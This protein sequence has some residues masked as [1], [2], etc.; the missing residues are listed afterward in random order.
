MTTPVLAT[1]PQTLNSYG[2]VA[3]VQNQGEQAVVRCRH[4]GFRR[5]PG[6]CMNLRRAKREDF[7]IPAFAGMTVINW[8]P[9]KGE[10]WGRAAIRVAPTM[11]TGTGQEDSWVGRGGHKGRPYEVGL[12]YAAGGGPGMGA[13]PCFHSTAGYVPMSFEVPA[14]AGRMVSARWGRAAPGHR[15]GCG[16]R[17]WRNGGYPGRA[18]A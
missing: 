7:W 2:A 9:P 13:G 8:E 5:N 10:Q 12:G 6:T 15:R 11:D 4:T 14:F 1:Y 16:S 17:S 3:T 18:S